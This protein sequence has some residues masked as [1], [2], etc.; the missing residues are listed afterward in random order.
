MYKLKETQKI[1]FSAVLAAICVVV[2]IF[3]FKALPGL[4]ISFSY[5]PNFLAGIFLGPIYG[6]AVGLV[7][8]LL[9]T[10]IKGDSWSVLITIGNTLIGVLMGVAFRYAYIKNVHMKII[11]GAFMVLVIVTYGINTLGLVLPPVKLYPTFPI[12]LATRIPQAAMLALNTAIT[13][14]LYEALD[15]TIFAPYKE[16]KKKGTSVKKTK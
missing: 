15:R 3:K 2:K 8:D 1:A 7:G 12:A 5:I 11:F 16:G 10:I 14:G 13:V 9:G 4:D 6:G